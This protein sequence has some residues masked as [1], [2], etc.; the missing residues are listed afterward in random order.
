MPDK[1]IT[2]KLAIKQG[3]NVLF[4]DAPKGY[5]AKIGSLPAGVTVAT[6]VK[7][8]QRV[9]VAQVFVRTRKE[10]EEQLMK[11][12]PIVDPK[13]IIWV[14]YPKGTSKTYADINRDIVR[15][16]AQTVSLQAVAIFPVD[17]NWSAMRLK[18]V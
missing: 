10:L 17:E 7:A 2:Q 16:Y 6:A 9:D 4:L 12:R 18:L 15:E 8:G 13:G 1:T 14:T 11:V 3:Q 5:D